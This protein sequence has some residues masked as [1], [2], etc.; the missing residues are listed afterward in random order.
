MVTAPVV[1][2]YPPSSPANPSGLNDCQQSVVIPTSSNTS[3]VHGKGRSS[4]IRPPPLDVPPSPFVPPPPVP[5][6][7]VPPLSSV[8]PSEVPPSPSVPPS[9]GLPPLPGLL[10][11]ADVPP[12]SS[13]LDPPVASPSSALRPMISAHPKDARATRKKDARLT[14]GQPTTCELSCSR[15]WR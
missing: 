8:P 2:S 14:V 11:P 13:V 5:P 15:R 7:D 6:L 1:C 4:T 10:P 12:A 9:T 3:S